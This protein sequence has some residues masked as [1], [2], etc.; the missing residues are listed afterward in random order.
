MT[1]NPVLSHTDIL[2]LLQAVKQDK[3]ARQVFLS[4][5]REDQL[6]SI[7]GIIAYTNSQLVILQKEF[8]EH[9]NDAKRYRMNREAQ[10]KKV[11]DLAM[12]TGQKIAEGIRRELAGRFDFWLWF[13]DKVLPSVIT[14]ATL[15]LLYFVFGGKLPTP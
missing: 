5:N 8:I 12:T 13:R 7:L 11:G 4:M 6:L 14:V 2:E 15:T 3:E 10:E 1:N 9:K